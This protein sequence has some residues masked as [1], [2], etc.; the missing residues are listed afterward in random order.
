MRYFYTILLCLFSISLSAQ[1]AKKDG[2]YIKRGNSYNTKVRIERAEP[3]TDDGVVYLALVGNSITATAN[4]SDSFLLEH[5][6]VD[7]KI[8]DNSVGGHSIY[9]Q[10]TT[11]DNIAQTT[12]DSF[13]FVH[14]MVGVND[15][16][17]G[18]G[19]YY[20]TAVS[21]YN[22]LLSNIHGDIR[23]DCKIIMSV[24]TPILLADN[25]TT[26]ESDE[27][28][29]LNEDFIME[30]PTYTDTVYDEN[31]NIATYDV[32]GLESWHPWRGNPR[33]G[34]TPDEI[35]YVH[36]NWVAKGLIRDEVH[37]IVTALNDDD[38]TNDISDSRV[39]FKETWVDWPIDTM[40]YESDLKEQW[41][42]DAYFEGIG[43]D[44]TVWT[45]DIET[46]DGSKTLK[47]EYW[48]G[49]CCYKSDALTT[50]GS[51]V[52]IGLY[53]YG[54]WDYDTVAYSFNMWLSN[55]FSNPASFKLPGWS[56]RDSDGSDDH[57]IARV[58]V[59]ENTAYTGK[60]NV[61]NHYCYNVD[62]DKESDA[63]INYEVPIGEWVNVTVFL[64][65]GAVGR[66]GYMKI[67][68]N[69]EQNAGIS[70]TGKSVEW[71]DGS[72]NYGWNTFEFELNMGG[73]DPA[74]WAP[75]FDSD[76]WIDDLI[77]WEPGDLF[78]ESDI[79]DDMPSDANFDR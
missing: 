71:V 19:S 31:W 45:A 5:P 51:A 42:E 15:L 30:G 21:R 25:V 43:S 58:T 50:W 78:S 55:P 75:S 26:A 14:V 29:S 47:A 66:N 33:P 69:G 39:F 28:I 37:A 40:L 59:H 72:H 77:L 16:M 35:D 63:G 62:G 70:T 76:M 10:D 67:Y 7:Y 61:Y 65:V 64:D 46:F 54:D 23:S 34:N 38:E 3:P 6:D 12:I 53:K 1:F 4:F 32:P 57:G 17:S 11:W 8:Y 27:L 36:P 49:D 22:S 79:S 18:N 2:K 56:N 20:S 73:N 68:I 44:T 9:R 24:M 48:E 52:N 41:G 74:T 13:D 60:N